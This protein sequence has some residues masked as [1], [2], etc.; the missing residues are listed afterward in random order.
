M[1]GKF[2][3]TAAF[4][5]AVGNVSKSDTAR[6]A[7]EYILLDLIDDDPANFYHVDG[8]EELAANIELCGLQQPIRVRPAEAG[9]YMIVSGHRRRAALTLL[10]KENPERWGKAPCIVER[11]DASPQLRELRLI[12]GNSDTRDLSPAEV[13]KQAQRVELLLYQLKE[14]GYQFP[15]RMRDQVAA[16]CKVS[17]PKLARLKVIREKLIPAYLERFDRNGLPEQTAYALARME[18]ALQERLAAMLPTVPTGGRAEELLGLAKSGT[19]WRP[20]FSCPDGSPCTRK[21]AFLRHDVDCF[22]GELCKGETCCLKCHRATVKYSACDR[23]CS[24]AKAARKEQRDEEAAREAERGAK[25]QEEIRKNVQLRAKR[26]AEA[27]DS[28]GLDDETP[29]YISGYG[30]NLTVGELREWAAG[31]FGPDERLYPSTLDARDF[32]DPGRTAKELGCST[33]YL[34]G[35][36]DQ[37]TPTAQSA[38]TESEEDGPWHW[39]PDQPTEPGLYWCV[40]GPMSHGGVLYWWNAEEEQWEHPAMAFRMSPTVTLWMKCPALPESMAWER[41]EVPDGEE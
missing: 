28:A 14:Q 36:T 33:D 12:M 25:I 20:A 3:I 39:W 34:L 40:T 5:A 19:D 6:E 41:Q 29:I 8:L 24:K 22:Y 2:D 38:S 27:A 9:R 4:Q 31:R 32:S 10:A 23:A 26:L 35:V 7:I 17:A 13:S 21:D 1:G 16:A 18:Q 37:L 11:D 15:G 30:R